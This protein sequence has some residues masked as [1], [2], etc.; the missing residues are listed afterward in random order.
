MEDEKLWTDRE[1][2]TRWNLSTEWGYTT[3]QKW[4]RKGVLECTRI[5]D[6][7]RFTKSQIED[8]E[9]RHKA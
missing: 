1:L 4:V 2:A 3:I 7:Y 9:S 5:G 8:Y 6:L